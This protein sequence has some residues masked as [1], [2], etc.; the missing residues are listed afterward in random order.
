MEQPKGGL[1]ARV[2]P[3]EQEVTAFPEAHLHNTSQASPALGVGDHQ[4]NLAIPRG[5]LTVA[6]AS[7]FK[8][9]V[10]DFQILHRPIHLER[11]ERAT[12]TLNTQIVRT[13]H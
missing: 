9:C 6:S 11:L 1:R 10:L 13:G 7:W 8:F 4:P 5:F 3:W 2:R 12:L